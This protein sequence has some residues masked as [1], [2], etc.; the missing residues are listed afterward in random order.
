MSYAVNCNIVYI[1]VIIDSIRNKIQ[2]KAIVRSDL[3]S[4]AMS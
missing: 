2:M 1:E 4:R 3:A